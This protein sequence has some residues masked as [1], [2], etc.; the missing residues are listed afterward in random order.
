MIQRILCLLLLFLLLSGLAA[1]ATRQPVDTVQLVTGPFELEPF[2]KYLRFTFN[3]D[4]HNSF[5]DRKSVKV[6]GFAFGVRHK[7]VHTLGAGLYFL[8]NR[9]FDETFDY[10][11]AEQKIQYEYGYATLFYE[12]TLYLS[13]RWEWAAKV[14]W[15]GGNATVYYNPFGR[16]TR[17]VLDQIR[18]DVL[19]LSSSV[20]YN[21]FYWLGIGTG[22]GY[23]KFYNAPDDISV[24]FSSPTYVFKVQFRV[25][26]IARSLI[27][28]SVKNEY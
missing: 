28:K 2:H 20:T 15:G 17:K 10:D 21:V 8:N 7:R 19:D 9:I 5:F 13:R 16:N 1:N 23:R 4:A 14:Q 12:R 18:F 3:F 22:I 11:I 25:F 6:A 24:S 27:D 26:R